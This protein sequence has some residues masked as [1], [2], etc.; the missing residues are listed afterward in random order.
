M[1]KKTLL[2]ITITAVALGSVTQAANLIIDDFESYNDDDNLVWN[3]WCDGYD[4]PNNGSL[5]GYG[6]APFMETGIVYDGDQSMPF[7]FDNTGGGESS[8][9]RTFDPPVD[10]DPYERLSHYFLGERENVG[11]KLYIEINGVRTT[12]DTALNLGLWKQC[13]IDLSTLG[14]DLSEVQTLTIGVSGSNAQGLLYIDDV[15]LYEEGEAPTVVTPVDPGTTNLEFQYN[16]EGGLEDTS[17]HER[18]GFSELYLSFEEGLRAGV[19]DMGM[20]LSLDCT[21]GYYISFP[22]D[23]LIATLTDSTFSVWL[24][25]DEDRV[26]DTMP[27]F[28]FCDANSSDYMALYSSTEDDG[29]PKFDIKSASGQAQ[30]VQGQKALTSGCWHHMAVVIEDA[31]MK[32]YVD[33]LLSDSAETDTLP[34]DLE[35]S[36][37]NYLALGRSPC[38]YDDL[39]CGSL[40][41]ILGYSRALSEGEV[42]YLA[43]DRETAENDYPYHPSHLIVKTTC[44]D[45]NSTEEDTMYDEDC[46]AHVEEIMNE[47]SAIKIHEFTLIDAELWDISA[48]SYSVEEAIEKYG[49]D[50]SWVY[51]EPDYKAS[52]ALTPNDPNYSKS[53]GLPKICI[54]QAWDVNTINDVNVAVIDSG[55]DYTHEDLAANMWVNPDE[56]PG[57][58]LD[59]DKNGYVDDIY[60]YDFGE[61]DNDP[62]DDQGHGTH[63]AG[64]IAARGNNRIGVTG[65]N[66]QGKLMALKI[67]DAD[68]VPYYSYGMKALE[69]AVDKG[70]QL[71]N[72]SWGGDFYHIG[73]Y[74]AIKSATG[75][76]FVAAAGNDSSDNDADPCYPASYNLDNIISVAATNQSDNLASFSNYGLTS[77]DL[78]APGDYIYSTLPGNSYGYKSGTSMAAPYVTGVAS[79][80]GIYDRSIL[81]FIE[82][83]PALTGKTV[84]GGRLSLCGYYP[85]LVATSNGNGSV[86]GSGFYATGATASITATPNAHYHFV[87]WTATGSVVVDDSSSANTTVTVNGSG[88]VKANFAID[89][90]DLTVSSTSGG[91]VTA[92]GVGTFTYDYGTTVSLNAVADSLYHFTGWTGTAVTAGKVVSTTSASTS[93]TVDGD[94]TLE[95]CF[96]LKAQSSNVIYVDDDALGNPLQ[97][98]TLQQPCAEIQQAIDLAQDRDTVIV[99]PGLYTESLDFKGKAIHVTSLALADPKTLVDRETLLPI[100]GSN[101][102]NAIE[103]TIIHGDYAGP[104]VIF[105]NGENA[106]S[107]LS[108]FTLTGGRDIYGGAIQCYQSAPL[109]SHCVITGNRATRYSGG[110][111]DCF[112][113]E[114]TFINCTISHN[115]ARDEDGA[116]ITCEDS[117]DVFVN[118]ILWDNVPDQIQTV[119]GNDPQISYCDIEGTVWPGTGNISVD[120]C[121]AAP[122]TWVDASN[123][124]IQVS[125][126][127]IDAHWLVGDYHVQSE[128]GRYSSNLGWVC[129][130]VTSACIDTGNPSSDFE[131]ES[132]PNG[133][134]INIGAYGGTP[135]ASRSQPDEL[136]LY[137]W[138]M[139]SDPSWSTQGQWQYGIPMGTGGAN[140]YPDP[141]SGYTGA[142]VYGVNLSG[143]YDS[144]VGGP[145]A[146]TC[147]PLDC[148]GYDQVTLRFWRWLNS[149][150]YP[151]VSQ[152]LEYSLDG[153]SWNLLW[154]NGTTSVTDDRWVQM[155]HPLNLHTISQS[156]VY[157]RWS[158]EIKSRAFQYSGWNIDD[159]EIVVIDP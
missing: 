75:H 135:E 2:L 128:F 109:I 68:G 38:S 101:G 16:M 106:N 65:V 52:F 77:V 66:W 97:D 39:Y 4:D 125:A 119:Y 35:S 76:L 130:L 42:R 158:Y 153:S 90:H 8:A 113:S 10:W 141:T 41:E 155:T 92:P 34:C 48:G 123:A 60:G 73:L 30:V 131:L 33:G 124:G 67:S 46:L 19:L 63:V 110:A 18:D 152:S 71:S 138:L 107:V 111:V 94:Y 70:V 129:D 72:N 112:Q 102:L 58:N 14:V 127:D 50:S 100:Q 78:G 126:Q 43:G 142:S 11:G 49:D 13:V 157:L 51:F 103:Q 5:V 25:M 27:V 85:E 44:K 132:D 37:Y 53:W 99:L 57:N 98:G 140:G 1:F 148:T 150:I 89:E 122:G 108:G 81:D 47:L 117:N 45:P 143:D 69:Y 115:V 54:E 116:A 159:V 6:V 28:S 55:I 9:I 20:A 105:A 29:L 15:C 93:V 121:F 24:C 154:E 133:G 118:C 137:Q 22:I 17:G 95:A 59:D 136:I 36:E 61:D 134:C 87:N 151:Y 146:L 40:D 7:H 3:S 82:Q 56:I 114:A 62:M 79:L 86:T 96:V 32:L 88:T 104:V 64:I 91:S 84:T 12:C 31:T 26:G 147:G 149:D 156:T 74:E 139:D 83:V 120:P 80:L 145:Y 23:D 21:E 144:I